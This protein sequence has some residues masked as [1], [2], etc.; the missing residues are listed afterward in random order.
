MSY[1]PLCPI[2]NYPIS[3]SGDN[4][5]PWS[6]Q[7]D[8][9]PRLVHIKCPHVLP[10]DVTEVFEET[11]LVARSSA[12]QIAIDSESRVVTPGWQVGVDGNYWSAGFA[13][14]PGETTE[15]VREQ[16]REWGATHRHLL[17]SSRS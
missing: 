1:H 12:G 2:C 16:L 3:A 4:V 6:V 14:K 13:G 8:P 15:W 11:L 10:D 7:D 9:Q 5:K 17:P